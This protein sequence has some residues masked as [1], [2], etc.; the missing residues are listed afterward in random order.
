MRPSDTSVRLALLAANVLRFPFCLAQS[1]D[2]VA[3]FPL[4]A[5]FEDFNALKTFQDIAFGASGAGGAETTMLRHKN[6]LSCV[7]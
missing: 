2:T 4:A 7:V 3:G 5:L 1:R 6:S